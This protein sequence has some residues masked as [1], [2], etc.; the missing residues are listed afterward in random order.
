MR[1]RR[2]L[3]L[4]SEFGA[5]DDLADLVAETDDVDQVRG[6][7]T[8]LWHA[9]FGNRS[10][11]VAILLDAG[12]DPHRPM[13]SGWTPARLSLA[14][15]HPLPG[16]PPLSEAEADAVAV[17]GELLA[18]LEPP[19]HGYDGFGL[20]CVAGIGAAE[21]A[22]R[23][24]GEETEEPTSFDPWS[25]EDP[26]EYVVGVT[27]VPGGC[28]VTQ[29]WWFLPSMTGIMNRLSPGTDCYGLYMNPKSGPQGS[30]SSD[31]MYVQ[32][33]S[34]GSG[35]DENDRPEEVLAAYLYRRNH[36][37]YA[38]A[39]AGLRPTDTRAVAGPADLWLRLPRLKY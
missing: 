8:A 14:G 24:D 18:A 35:P 34:P 21:A 37:A 31:G 1:M 33:H 19:A 32:R 25:G 7:R 17:A 6:G 20:A 39:F 15:P 3:Y 16:A 5:A 23:L 12:A 13:M 4:I 9:V 38:C 29:P 26:A 2:D 30:V 22:R 11:N 10:D 27:D 28:V 36:V